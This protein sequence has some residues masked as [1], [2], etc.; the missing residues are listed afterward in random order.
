MKDTIP[1]V[2]H[3]GKRL[4]IEQGRRRGIVQ[5][6]PKSSY[7]VTPLRPPPTLSTIP[8]C[9][10][11]LWFVRPHISDRAYRS[12]R[13]LKHKRY[14]CNREPQHANNAPYGTQMLA[15]GGGCGQ[16]ATKLHTPSV[17]V[18]I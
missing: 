7:L 13:W 14:D 4:D 8:P 2:E 6:L 9:P 3:E 11:L 18:D 16:T 5:I 1:Q 12:A 10:K 17:N 15:Q